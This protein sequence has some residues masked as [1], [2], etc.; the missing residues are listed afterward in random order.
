MKVTLRPR[1]AP[2]YRYLELSSLVLALALVVL[3][4]L[5][6]FETAIVDGRSMEPTLHELEY[7]LVS[8]V[9]QIHRGQIVVVQTPS[10]ENVI[11]RVIGTKG[12]L[13]KLGK[14]GVYLNNTV[15]YEPYIQAPFSFSDDYQVRVPK[16]M[17]FVL[18]DN[19]SNSEDSRDYGPL[20]LK[21]ARGRALAVY[22]PLSRLRKL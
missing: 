4:R 5:F 2:Y 8:Q 11:K 17:I 14:D 16:G 10:G 20:P 3:L 12:D 18:G 6:V 13:V 21:A 1:R 15:L 22:Y 9:G 19:R 7:V